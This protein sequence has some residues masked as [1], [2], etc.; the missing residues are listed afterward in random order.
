VAVAYDDDHTRAACDG[1]NDDNNGIRNNLTKEIVPRLRALNL[2][3]FL[4]CISYL[5]KFFSENFRPRQLKTLYYSI[6]RHSNVTKYLC[7][8]LPDIGCF[9]IKHL[10]YECQN[11]KFKKS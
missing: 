7:F 1:D 3:C 8:S 2:I 4:N 9:H 5:L 10:Q 6:I 11:F